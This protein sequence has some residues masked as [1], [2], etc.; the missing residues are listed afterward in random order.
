MK[1]LSVFRG[2]LLLFFSYFLVH[3][4]YKIALEDTDS[5]S[6]NNEKAHAVPVFEEADA[7]IESTLFTKR[8]LQKKYDETIRNLEFPDNRCLI[9]QNRDKLISLLNK[10]S[11]Y[12]DLTNRILDLLNTDT[13]MS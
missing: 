5:V 9:P 12:E 6:I 10:V 3:R 8:I 11:E 4:P 13:Q 7:D 1:Y 2:T